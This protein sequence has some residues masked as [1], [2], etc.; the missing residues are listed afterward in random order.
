MISDRVKEISRKVYLDYSKRISNCDMDDLDKIEII[1]DDSNA[2]DRD[3]LGIVI[4]MEF[5]YGDPYCTSFID[6]YCY[7][8]GFNEYFAN[9]KENSL[10]SNDEIIHGLKS[11]KRLMASYGFFKARDELKKGMESD[12]LLNDKKHEKIK[13]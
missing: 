7:A 8:Y 4:A 13:C 10:D 6:R 1:L 5:A 3:Y 2:T 11:R 9:V 12:G